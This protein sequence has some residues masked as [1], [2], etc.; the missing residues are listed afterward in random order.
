[1]NTKRLIQHGY[2]PKEL[3]PP[4]NT[5]ALGNKSRLISNA[6]S[7]V[8]KEA[9]KPIGGEPAKKA[10]NRYYSEFHPLYKYSRCVKFNIPK[11][12]HTRRKLEIPNPLH[13]TELCETLIHNWSKI[14][15]TYKLTNISESTPIESGAQRAVR[16]KSASVNN[17]NLRKLHISFDKRFEITFDIAQFYPSL[18]T[19]SISWALLGKEKAKSFLQIKTSSKEKWNKLKATDEDAKIYAAADHIDAKVRNCQDQQSI[20]FP[21]GPDTSFILAETIANRL[22][23]EIEQAL[24]DKD[25]TAIRYYDDYVFYTDNYNDAEKILKVGQTIFQK[26]SLESNEKKATIK[27]APFIYEKLWLLRLLSLKFTVC[28]QNNLKEY[29]SL[30][31]SLLKQYPADESSQI[32]LFSLSRFVKGYSII[33]DKKIWKVFEKLVLQTMLLDG[34]NLKIVLQLFLAYEKFI[35]SESKKIIKSTLLKIIS[36]HLEL[37]HS[38]EVAWSLWILKS[39]K[40]SINSKILNQVLL[41][42]D[43]I[44]KLIALDL[45]VCNLYVGRKPGTSHLSRSLT[46]ENFMQ[47]D[48]LFLYE[49]LKK[50]WIQPRSQKALSSNKYMNLLFDYDIE[51]YDSNRQVASSEIQKKIKNSGAS[52][53]DNSV[54][55][56][57]VKEFSD[58][59]I[60]IIDKVDVDN[61]KMQEKLKN[62][63]TKNN[64]SKQIYETLKDILKKY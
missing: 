47:D 24:K 19:H 48:W 63:F 3:P 43:C 2:F 14:R 58:L 45:I 42:D 11:G 37:G 16:T 32:I 22:D 61:P 49:S 52:N 56:K 8:K 64:M 57:K 10:K 28:S 44:S 27:E 4:F 54:A 38:Y 25:Y 33:S 18:Y 29:F 62:A 21:I 5:D 41:S 51:F 59:L 9:I 50:G 46:S 40:I 20:G 34:N 15:E 1:M 39:L 60:N 35:D 7:D 36:K 26:Y 17:F 12:I 30:V 55:N 23:F 31:F 13:F 6:W 53:S